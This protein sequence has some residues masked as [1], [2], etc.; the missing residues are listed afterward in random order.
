MSESHWFK[1][2][3]LIGVTFV[4]LIELHQNYFDQDTFLWPSGSIGLIPTPGV[5]SA[6][7]PLGKGLTV[8][9]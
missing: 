7:I 6:A 3:F 1:L 8:I 4:K 2:R 5:F 9:T